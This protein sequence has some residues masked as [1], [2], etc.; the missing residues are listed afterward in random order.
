LTAKVY[1][2]QLVGKDLVGGIN[3][4]FYGTTLDLPGGSEENH[5]KPE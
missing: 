2:I 4:P 1:S 5:E 3:G